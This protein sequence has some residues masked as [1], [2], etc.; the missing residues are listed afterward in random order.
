MAMTDLLPAS[1]RLVSWDEFVLL[2]DED[3]R[4]L[5]DG[6]L[7]EV[8][9]PNRA[10]E[11][12]VRVLIRYLDEWVRHGDR[13]EVFPSGY[14][15]R[16][17]RDRGV[18]PD[19]QIVGREVNRSENEVGL[20]AGTPQLVVEVIS[21]SSVRYDRVIKLG[22]Y[23]VAGVPEYWIVDPAHRTV[24][25]LVLENG[26]YFIAETASEGAFAPGGY[27]GLSIP[28]AELFPEAE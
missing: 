23:Q 4:E 17:A 11:R 15:V 1:D 8:E 18:M 16:I 20:V 22:Y 10:H 2:D 21:P 12:A 6:R 24:E 25:R 19:L 3:R 5:I 27:D 7:V 28:F 26:K 9:V 13:G 14:K